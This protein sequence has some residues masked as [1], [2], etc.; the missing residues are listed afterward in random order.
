M[1]VRI[2]QED[3]AKRIVDK[4]GDRVDLS[5]FE[6]D[7]FYKKSKFICTEHNTVVIKTVDALLKSNKV[8]KSCPNNSD[9]LLDDLHT[10][11]DKV[12]KLQGSDFKFQKPD[13]D[14]IPKDLYLKGWC[15]K[16]GLENTYHKQYIIKHKITACK[17]CRK[18][19]KNNYDDLV[20]MET[21]HLDELCSLY[22]VKFYKDGEYQFDK[23]G[24]CRKGL[25][26]RFR[27]RKKYGYV[28]RVVS[29]YDSTTEDCIRREHKFMEE[30]EN[31]DKRYRVHDLQN[32]TI[33]GWTE[34]FIDNDSIAEL[35]IEEY[36]QNEQS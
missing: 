36:C 5:C 10:Y 20:D 22:H 15:P 35:T 26:W 14:P 33:C 21:D 18:T 29:V 31:S 4:F 8:C 34:C 19:Y 1:G 7:G 3:I 16:C 12:Y 30:L 13:V 17:Y 11:L 9:Y 2:K 25:L 28:I 23:V 6:Y 24:I 27:P 32:T